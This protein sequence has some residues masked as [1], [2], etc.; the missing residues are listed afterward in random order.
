M[1]SSAAAD[2]YK[3]QR[4]NCLACLA[5]VAQKLGKS[6]EAKQWHQKATTVWDTFSNLNE[7]TFRYGWS[8][9][10]VSQLLLNESSA[11]VK[12]PAPKLAPPLE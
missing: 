11:A 5:M 3:R 1:P 12:E 9:I 6:V 10:L 8:D 2:V 7:E 4:A